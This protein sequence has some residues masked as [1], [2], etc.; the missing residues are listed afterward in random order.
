MKR[1]RSPNLGGCFLALPATF[2]LTLF[3][4]APL[5][6]V[7]LAS[8]WERGLRGEVVHN[9]T[10]EN[11]QY[12]DERYRPILDRS[13]GIAFQTTLYALVL[14]FPLAY[15]ITTRQ[16]QWARQLSLFLVILPFW[17]NFL[18][19]TYAWQV[20]L[21]T[22]GVINH[23]FQALGLIDEPLEILYTQKAV[24]IGMVYGFL[25]FMVLPIYASLERFDFKMVEAAKDLGANEFSAFV[26]IIFP[27]TLP[28]VIA[29]CILVFV[30]SVGAFVT[31]DLLGGVEGLM[32]G[33]LINNAFRRRNMPRGSATSIVLMG[34]V[35]IGLFLYLFVVERSSSGTSSQSPDDEENETALQKLAKNPIAAGSAFAGTTVSTPLMLWDDVSGEIIRHL[36]IPDSVRRWRDTTVQ[37][38]GKVIMLLAPIVNYVFLWIPI[39]VLVTFSFNDSRSTGV[40]RGFSTRWYTRI[41]DSVARNKDDFSTELM[42]ETLQNSMIVSI[43]ATIIAAILGTMIAMS[44]VRGRFPGKNLL[45]GLLY[46]PVAIPEIAQAFSLYIFFNLAFDYLRESS[47]AMAI[48]DTINYVFGTSY[49]WGFGYSTIIISHVAFNISFVAIVVRARLVDMNPRYEEA[50]RDLGA[51]EWATFWRVTFPILFPAIMAGAL[52]AFT[53]SLDDFVITL[54]TTGIGT[55]TLTVYVYGLLKQTVTPEI[56]A[57][58]TLMILASTFLVGLSLL[59]QGRSASRV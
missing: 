10:M 15:F 42:L 43:S 28:G 12:V 40:W 19:R 33:N 48:V 2:W 45:A 18:I 11:Y 57:I 1:N 24:L 35:A 4:L 55:T 9:W 36:N 30:P 21:G 14:G 8:F 38:T 6:I 3:F 5:V 51:N 44:I 26:R 37:L 59:L 16:R 20:L 58:S 22:N 13:L 52:L 29:G 27:L 47:V 32:I 23:Y 25:P 34:I 49:D 17:T 39:V 56:N 54:M 7:I 31:P 53:L 41:T 46:L 50:A